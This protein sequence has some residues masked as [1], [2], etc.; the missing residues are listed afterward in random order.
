MRTVR[1]PV[2]KLK[3]VL[4]ANRREHKQ[5]YEQAKTGYQ[6]EVVSELSKRLEAAQSGE[7]VSLYFQGLYFQ[8]FN[9]PEDHTKDYDRVIK[10]LEMTEEDT[11]ELT[12]TEFGQYVQDEWSWKDEFTT[13]NS[14]YLNAAMR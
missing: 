2:A 6:A 3:E 4:E 8:G 9:R 13:S 7:K 11:V 1:L 14:K 5:A 12:S 10:M